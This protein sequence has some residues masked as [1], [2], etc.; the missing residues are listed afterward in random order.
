M[1]NGIIL[2]PV[3]RGVS[4]GVEDNPKPPALWAG[5]LRNG[6]KALL[7]VAHRQGIKG[8]GMVCPGETLGSLWISLAIR[9]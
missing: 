1:I 5:Y 9:A 6:R 8:S 4:K 3:Q 7:G 2:R